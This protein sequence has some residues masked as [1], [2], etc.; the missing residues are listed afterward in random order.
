M[1]QD[2]VYNSICTATHEVF[3][4]MLGLG[5]EAGPPST[6]GN[7]QGPSDG[8]VSLI[9]L[10][11]AWIGTG[12]IACPPSLACKISTHLV[13]PDQPDGEQAVNADVLDAVA[14]VTNMIIG[15]VKNLLEEELGP[16]GLSIPTVIFGRN[17]LTRTSSN[18]DWTVVPFACEGEHLEV[19]L[20]LS[21]AKALNPSR[22]GA[23]S[24][25][26]IVS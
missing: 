18:D 17:F 15:N 7:P 1:D 10:A 3:S 8:V 9:G 24:S 23:N 2:F 26:T 16:M 6:A 12:S 4:T 19:K 5:I 11:G 21:K 25:A 20:C 22:H 13:M 14:E